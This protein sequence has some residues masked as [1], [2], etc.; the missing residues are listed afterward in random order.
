MKMIL[1]SRF[2]ITNEENLNLKLKKTGSTY[3]PENATIII[4]L[5]QIFFTDTE[6]NTAS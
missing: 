1:N 3:T 6:V 4:N 5:K 2:Y